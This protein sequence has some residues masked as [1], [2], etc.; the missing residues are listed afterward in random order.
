MSEFSKSVA[1][2][3]AVSA[4]LL[5]VAC[6]PPAPDPDQKPAN[7]LRFERSG[8][9]DVRAGDLIQV[10][11]KTNS[12]PTGV[13]GLRVEVTGAAAKLVA[14]TAPGA[15][16][17]ETYEVTAPSSRCT[18]RGGPRFSSRPPTP[19]AGRPGPSAANT[20][21]SPSGST[22]RPSPPETGDPGSPSPGRPSA[23]GSRATS[24]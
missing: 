16:P 11:F 10:V 6:G 9:R 5:A 17:G 15:G 19:K 8:D 3:S 24:A 20:P 2:A 4:L 14:V 1:V 22:S 13:Q 18:R 23:R 7:L 21:T 12:A